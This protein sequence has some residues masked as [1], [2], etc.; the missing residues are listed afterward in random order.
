MVLVLDV[1]VECKNRPNI[2]MDTLHNT[3]RFHP[4]ITLKNWFNVHLFIIYPRP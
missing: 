4:K 2:E 1:F 3:R